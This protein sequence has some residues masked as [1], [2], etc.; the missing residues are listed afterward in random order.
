M[1]QRMNAMF[2]VAQQQM[3]P[4]VSRSPAPDL[5]M[6]GKDS[7]HP[8]VLVVDDNPDVRYLFAVVLDHAGYDVVSAS[9]AQAALEAAQREHFDVIVSDTGLPEMNGYELARAL[10]ALSDYVATPMIAV[11]RFEEYAAAHENA[12]NAGFNALLKKPVD[13]PNFWRSSRDW[14]TDSQASKPDMPPNVALSRLPHN[15]T[16]NFGDLCT[17]RQ[18]TSAEGRTAKPRSIGASGI[19]KLRAR[20]G[21]GGTEIPKGLELK[22]PSSEV[23]KKSRRWFKGVGQIAQG[24][25]L[26]IADVALVIG[27]L[28]LPVSA[29]TQTL[30]ALASVATG[31][32]TV[33]KGVGDLRNEYLRRCS[34][35]RIKRI[36]E[37]PTQVYWE[38]VKGS[39][40]S[41][42]LQ[43]TLFGLNHHSYLAYAFWDLHAAF[44]QIEDFACP[45]V[46][47]ITDAEAGLTI[48]QVATLE[49]REGARLRQARYMIRCSRFPLL[50]DQLRSLS[51]ARQAS[52]VRGL[53]SIAT[54]FR[55]WVVLT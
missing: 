10:R 30:G 19:E 38:N 17:W 25:A 49:K 9:S 27:V 39:R 8:L 13:P 3:E 37:F 7:Q 21:S 40:T 4:L 42:G 51:K 28:K 41:R 45:S 6:K 48:P 32:G 34:L 55:G 54:A 47:F 53:N 14:D 29:E 35:V 36:K 23:P 12:F 31:I 18:G 1:I 50:V 44:S 43:T 16:P 24:S 26:S 5:Q 2:S 52:F 33:L 20:T 22:E 46:R 11:T 15:Q